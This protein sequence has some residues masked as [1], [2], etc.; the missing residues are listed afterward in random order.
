MPG[1]RSAVRAWPTVHLGQA[2]GFLEQSL[3]L[4]ALDA[5]QWGNVLAR[6][7]LRPTPNRLELQQA[8]VGPADLP[9]LIVSVGES[10]T[11]VVGRRTLAVF[12]FACSHVI[13]CRRCRVFYFVR[14]AE[15]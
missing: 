1:D 9:R 4:A 7:S 6:R 8:V 15:S 3:A 10:D 14:H 13:N 12:P 5:H 2:G 11:D